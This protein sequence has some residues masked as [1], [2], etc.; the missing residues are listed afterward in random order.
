MSK[1]KLNNL[2]DKV[3]GKVGLLRV[4]AY[5]MNKLFKDIVTQISKTEGSIAAVDSKVNET[6]ASIPTKV[7]QLENDLGFANT[8]S[9][10]SLHS[11]VTTE[12]DQG[13]IN[14]IDFKSNIYYSISD[15]YKL[16]SP[17]GESVLY[18]FTTPETVITF[19]DGGPELKGFE[20]GLYKFLIRKDDV[21]RLYAKEK[22]SFSQ[23]IFFAEYP[24]GEIEKVANSS[25][26]KPYKNGAVI[27][28]TN[29]VFEAGDAK[30][31]LIA[32]DGYSGSDISSDEH[33]TKIWAL[34]SSNL[35]RN[36]ND[37]K[38]LQEAYIGAD[39]S[40]SSQ[41]PL[42]KGCGNLRKISGPHASA[43]EKC[44]LWRRGDYLYLNSF[45]A[46]GMLDYEIEHGVTSIV[47]SAFYGSRLRS[48]KIPDT[49]RS[50]GT[51][52][53]Y[54]CEDLK[55]VH[56]SD[57]S[58]WCG[59]YYGSEINNFPSFIG[60]PLMYGA[61]LY[62]NGSEVTDMIIPDDVSEIKQACFYGCSSITSVTIGSN[63]IT[64]GAGAFRNCENLRSV[65][66]ENAE[67][68][69]YIYELAFS[70]SAIITIS[71]PDA[72]T[73]IKHAVCSGCRSLTSV[74]FPRDVK[75]IGSI[76]FDY[77]DSV[78]YYDFSKALQVPRI[79]TT[80]FRNNSSSIKI[81]VPDALYSS[82]KKA[83]NWSALADKIIKKS[84]WDAQQ[85]TE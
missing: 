76:A 15:K 37:C 35:S 34:G 18:L 13:I 47:G 10:P 84:D 64:L 42:F 30:V 77:C 16:N 83:T 25:T 53:F 40:L 69:K 9:L 85:T 71:F 4:P 66:F 14:L 82:W 3:V 32:K 21:M 52:A 48:I 11:V 58:K 19:S 28:P 62:L 38:N 20:P 50:I 60:S 24:A 55:E 73:D 54:G 70:G 7:S 68:L 39:I 29:V 75:N 26:L 72:V 6:K 57:L 2:I 27:S 80:S 49:L 33:I 59:I 74:I 46:G 51:Q 67:N 31:L 43:D 5:W 65:N 23:P 63:L 44:L 79:E 22:V 12:E 17:N 8:E 45:A 1:E 81:I 78:Q 61:K 41:Y 56:I 36:L